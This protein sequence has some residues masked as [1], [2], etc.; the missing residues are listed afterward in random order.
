MDGMKRLRG[1]MVGA[2]LA[3]AALL[4]AAGAA[5]A[6]G[7]TKLAS[8][9]VVL[10]AG[11]DS[12][13]VFDNAVDRMTEMLRGRAGIE[14]YRL[15]SDRRLGS[16]TRAIASARTINGALKGSGAEGCFV[17]LTSHGTEKGLYLREDQDSDRV[18]SPSRL[19]RILDAQC[20]DRPTAVV[21]SAC[22]SGVFIGKASRGDNR[23]WLTAAREDRVS[24]GCGAQFE[25]TY[26]DECLIG[27]WPKSRTF[28]Q[29]FDRAEACVR[30]K[31][32]ELSEASSM[33]QAFFGDGVK[34]LE[35]P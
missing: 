9:R 18:L 14:L 20:G 22:H 12:A 19:D 27:A 6:T 13:P 1:A 7:G 5:G 32:S 25:L 34:D 3:L 15:T 4:P 29:L 16:A 31:E 10:V 26:F 11:D 33:P 8:W 23:I 2:A 17:F 28:A 21:V 30:R 35:L 24:F